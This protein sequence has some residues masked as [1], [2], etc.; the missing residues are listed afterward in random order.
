MRRIVRAARAGG[1]DV[2]VA[3][4][5]L[6][7]A[8]CL[9]A[10]LVSNFP[11]ERPAATAVL[12]LISLAGAAAAVLLAGLAHVLGRLLRPA[13]ATPMTV[14]RTLRHAATGAVAVQLALPFLLAADLVLHPADLVGVLGGTY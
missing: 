9:G 7:V 12:T 14:R 10:W 3:L 6:A 5:F 2:A 13:R 11:H 8:V 1:P 4:L